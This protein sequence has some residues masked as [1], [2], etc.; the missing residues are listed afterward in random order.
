MDK[1]SKISFVI[2]A[3]NCADTL[4]ESIDSIF[5]KNFENG[6]EV[7]IVNDFS[8][9]DTGKKIVELRKKYPQI[10]YIKNDQN[11]GC[12][13]SRNIGIRKSKNPLIFN[14]DADNILAEGSIK[15]LKEYLTSEKADVAAFSEYHYFKTDTKKIDHKWVY[16]GG[17]MSLADFLAGPI[18][19]GPGGNF[20]Y[21]KKGWEKIGGYWE[22][23]KGLHEAWGYT[24]KHLA[25]G[26]KFVVL[27]NSFY[28]HRFGGDSL[29][30]RE[31]KKTDE[32]SLMATK[33]LLNFAH[34][35]TDEDAEYL[36]SDWGSRNW[37]ELFPERPLHIKSREVGI[38]GNKISRKNHNKGIL[39][40]KK[41]I[42][43]FIKANVKNFQINRT[44]KK[45]FSRFQKLSSIR[46]EFVVSK[47][48]QKPSLSDKTLSTNFDAHYIYHPA[49]AARIVKKI[50][51]SV[52][53]DISSTLS[54]STMLSAFIPVNFY[55]YRPA[56]I[57]LDG[58]TSL[59][60][61][62]LDLPFKNESI[63]SLS[64]MHTI[65]HI[66]LGRYGD[67]ID[68]EGD[69]KAIK[70]LR[71]VLSKNGDLLFVVPVGIPKIC[72]NSH[73]IYSYEQIVKYFNGF[74]LIE[75][76]LVQ[77]NASK[78]GMITNATKEQSDAQSYGCG[79][80]WFKKI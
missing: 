34:L 68:P 33:M 51:P 66:G 3:Y 24:L 42:S 39:L 20:L 35:L 17:V 13:A 16:K 7:V 67:P 77:D 11:K 64:C 75:F 70:E 55:D 23:G 53:T 78:I 36:R 38:T 19:P 62:L 32:S 50:N 26:S 44:F 80:F 21:T 37:F 65:E 10:V 41:L 48:E 28:F 56:N 49:W 72:F 60:V 29:F 74:N 73:R 69:L 5:H 2:P 57:N 52:H 63:S 14:L 43:V 46:P 25:N 71:R 8:S 54:F 12:P 27:P 79:C 45:D 59:K 9:D 1:N 22:Y 61:D 31:S 18:N 6:D 58:L 30:V 15:K 47:K 76:S 4:E 40:V